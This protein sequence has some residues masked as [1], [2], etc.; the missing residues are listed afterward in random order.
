MR[1]NVTTTVVGGPEEHE[2]EKPS[3]TAHAGTFSGWA[4]DVTYLRFYDASDVLPSVTLTVIV[5]V[6]AVLFL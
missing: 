3:S 4:W 6:L 1:L 2:R 5:S